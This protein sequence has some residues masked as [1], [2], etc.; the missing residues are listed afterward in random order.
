M[1][2]TITSTATP[3]TDLGYLLFKN[4]GRVHRFELSFGSATVLYPEATSERCTVC[5]LLEV[6]PIGMVRRKAGPAGD[7]GI[8]AQYVNDRPYVASS[9]LS[10]AISEVFG[11]AMT[12]RSK[13]RPDLAATEIPLEASLPVL[14]SRGGERLIRSL[15]EPL[16]YSVT[17][18]SIALD[19]KFP[20]WGPS[21]YFSVRLAAKKRVKDLLAHINVLVPV[22]DDEKHYWVGDDEIEKLLRRGGDWLPGHPQKEEIARRYLKHRRSLAREAIDRLTSA[23]IDSDDDGT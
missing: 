2:L 10:V 1:L 15:F 3:A 12:G 14:P 11:T 22:L 9:F 19:S 17:V 18:D 6:D 7:G 8:F 16:G 13:D 20:E 5:L 23:P 21:Q 4:P